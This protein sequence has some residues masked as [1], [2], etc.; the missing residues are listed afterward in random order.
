MCY[1][2]LVDEI[3]SLPDKEFEQQEMHSVSQREP[4]MDFFS[5]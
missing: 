1:D 3:V 4:M 5:A 2:W